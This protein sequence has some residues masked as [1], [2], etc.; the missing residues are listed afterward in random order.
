MSF[1][2]ILGLV[3]L[4]L[5]A[6]GFFRWQAMRNP[7]NQVKTN[8]LIPSST[9][10]K[11]NWKTYT[12]EKGYFSLEYPTSW[13]SFLSSTEVNQTITFEG[14][15]GNIM[16]TWGDGLGGACGQNGMEHPLEKFTIGKEVFDICHVV[17]GGSEWWRLIDKQIGN[18]GIDINAEAKPPIS[19]NR[20]ILLKVLNS[21]KFDVNKK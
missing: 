10:E 20:V 19:T 15:E 18:V 6:L 14:K 17:D 13:T 21:L 7:L 2:K 5:L 12:S 1:L 4:I 9:S 3:L 16:V 8:H 11:A